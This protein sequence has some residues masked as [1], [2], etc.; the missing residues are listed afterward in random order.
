M[1]G[2][3]Q[4]WLVTPTLQSLL[5]LLARPTNGPQ[6]VINV[7]RNLARIAWGQK[8]NDEAFETLF[9][10][11][12][13]AF[14]KAQPECDLQGLAEVASTTLMQFV[15]SRFD[16]PFQDLL[17]R[18]TYMTPVRNIVAEVH[19]VEERVAARVGI[20]LDR[21]LQKART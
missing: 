20:A 7:L 6:G 2:K 1:P 11:I 10:A 19:A 13:V 21:A 16:G 18:S 4:I 14:K 12:F 3:Y 17:R 9:V 5:D 8:P 15:R